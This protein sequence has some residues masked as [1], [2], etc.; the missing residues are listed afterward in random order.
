MIVYVVHPFRGLGRP[1]E[2]ERNK[3]AIAAICRE[4]IRQGHLPLSPVHALADFLDD[5]D[6]VQRTRA[7]TL[8]EKLIRVADVVEV[9]GDWLDSE[10][11]RREVEFAR[12]M[13]KPVRFQVVSAVGA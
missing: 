12:T 3:A 7:L 11:C 4:L 5:T 2:R 9:Y 6:P 1:G 10:G 13:G 8:C